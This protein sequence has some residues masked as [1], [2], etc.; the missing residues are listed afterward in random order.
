[1]SYHLRGAFAGWKTVTLQKPVV[2]SCLLLWL[3]TRG[4]PTCAWAKTTLALAGWKFCVRAWVT[5]NVNY[6]PWCKSLLACVCVCVCVCVCACVCIVCACVYIVCTFTHLDSSRTETR[7][8]NNSTWMKPARSWWK[9]GKEQLETDVNICMSF[10]S[11]VDLPA[12][13]YSENLR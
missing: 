3:S 13:S 7:V 1:M 9:L 10:K 12:S 5:P 6:R 4:W 8:L 11:K 2:R